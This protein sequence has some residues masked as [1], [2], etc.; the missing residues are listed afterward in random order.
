MRR[1]ESIAHAGVPPSSRVTRKLLFLTLR[2]T[3]SRRRRPAACPFALPCHRLACIASAKFSDCGVGR[4]TTSVSSERGAAD[5][6]RDA[7]VRP[8]LADDSGRFHDTTT[9]YWPRRGPPPEHEV[10]HLV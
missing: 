3:Q 6:G 4:P 7:D 9:H 8:E 1:V 10:G 2:A 5:G